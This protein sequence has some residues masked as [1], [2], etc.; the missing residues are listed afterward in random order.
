MPRPCQSDWR[1]LRVDGFLRRRPLLRVPEVD[2]PSTY[3]GP[4]YLRRFKGGEDFLGPL[5]RLSAQI[6]N[7]RFVT[8]I[9]T[10]LFATG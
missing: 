4:P 1:T 8:Q 2:A 7:D 9:V 5:F 10:Q 3:K 6:S